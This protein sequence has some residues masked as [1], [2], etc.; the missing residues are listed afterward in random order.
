MTADASP[1]SPLGFLSGLDGLR[2]PGGCDD[3]DA[4]QT[5]DST[6]APAYRVTVHHDDTCPAYRAMRAG[7]P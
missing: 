2:I 7:R 3:C 4:Y 5:V 1:E 6:L